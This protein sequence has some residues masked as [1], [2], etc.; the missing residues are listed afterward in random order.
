MKTPSAALLLTIS[1]LVAPS[2]SAQGINVV[3]L[4]DIDEASRLALFQEEDGDCRFYGSI[5]KVTGDV[6]I[7]IKT[8]PDVSGSIVESPYDATVELAELPVRA[9]TRFYIEQL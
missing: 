8:C 7:D 5:N 1:T 6:R 4:T 9:G 3:S 2:V